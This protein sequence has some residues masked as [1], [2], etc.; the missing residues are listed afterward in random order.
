MVELTYTEIDGI[1][2]PNITVPGSGFSEKDLTRYGLMMKEYLDREQP[3]LAMEL[4]KEFMYWDFIK[5]VQ[6]TADEMHE[7]VMERK[8]RSAEKSGELSNDIR[9]QNPYLW[10]Q[11]MTRLEVETVQVVS[12]ELIYS[13]GVSE[14][15]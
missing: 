15:G 13:V 9:N 6:E 5:N 12:S 14:E 4:Q 11:I 10:A 7:I 1:L 3:V 2:Y 8:V